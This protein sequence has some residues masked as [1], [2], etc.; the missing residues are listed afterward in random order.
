[1]KRKQGLAWIRVAGYHNDAAAATRIYIESRIS[2]EAH[3]RAFREGE[4][5]KANGMPCHCSECSK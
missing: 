3:D 1:M 5:A 2:R 4:R